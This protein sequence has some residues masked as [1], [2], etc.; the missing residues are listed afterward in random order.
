MLKMLNLIHWTFKK[1]FGRDHILTLIHFCCV[2]S[3]SE[4]VFFKTKASYIG[5]KQHK[6]EKN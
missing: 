2:K 6:G 5:L 4:I 1:T 3:F